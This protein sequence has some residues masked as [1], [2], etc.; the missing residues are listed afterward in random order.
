MSFQMLMDQ[1]GRGV[2][3]PPDT[4]VAG[5]PQ[6]H[7]QLLHRHHRAVVTHYGS[8][9]QE[10]PECLNVGMSGSLLSV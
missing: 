5:T 9:V 10:L 6:Q 8:P 7:E 1:W 3:V 4:P 2:P